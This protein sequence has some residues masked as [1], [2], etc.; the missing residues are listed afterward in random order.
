MKKVFPLLSTTTGLPLTGR[1]ITLVRTFPDDGAEIACAE[2]GV[3]GTYLATAIDPGLYKVFDR[4]G[5]AIP[6]TD[7]D[8]V[9]DVAAVTLMEPNLGNAASGFLAAPGKTFRA[10]AKTDIS[11]LDSD[12]TN[13]GTQIANAGAAITAE[14]NARI[15]SEAALG[16]TILASVAQLTS[17]LATDVTNIVNTISKNGLRDLSYSVGLNYVGAAVDYSGG[18]TSY[19]SYVGGGNMIF[20]AAGAL[21]MPTDIIQESVKAALKTR[22][23]TGLLNT[24]SFD[25]PKGLDGGALTSV[26][27]PA[28]GVTEKIRDLDIRVRESSAGTG[29]VLRAFID[30]MQTA[31]FDS[32]LYLSIDVSD[33]AIS[34][35]QFTE[36]KVW[37]FD[38]DQGGYSSC[39][40]FDVA[41]IFHFEKSKHAIRLK[42]SSGVLYCSILKFIEFPIISGG[43]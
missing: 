34:A 7:L 26:T 30:V 14:Q 33:P 19:R 31:D 2:L 43:V 32:V 9:V 24:N 39:F 23:V 22:F 20:V 17:Q 21:I 28:L 16:T 6:G 37:V 38:G 5:G 18:G 41:D 35:A 40:N 8:Q 4:T 42:R 36:V 29:R 13:L 12:I 3:T 1:Q 15:Q 27:A 25:N 11:G 10:V